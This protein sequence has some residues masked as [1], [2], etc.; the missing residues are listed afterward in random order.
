M[1]RDAIGAYRKMKSFGFS[2]DESYKIFEENISCM[3]YFIGNYFYL[4]EALD[5][6]SKIK[7]HRKNIRSK[8]NELVQEK[9]SES[10]FKAMSENPSLFDSTFDF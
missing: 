10:M 1:N 8:I 3:D 2:K 9:K 6:V 7:I 5:E 4:N